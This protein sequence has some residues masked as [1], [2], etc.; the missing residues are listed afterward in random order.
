VKGKWNEITAG[1]R[2]QMQQDETT[3]SF[4]LTFK[5]TATNN[6]NLIF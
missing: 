5:G 4:T 2:Y 1:D 3:A 6:S